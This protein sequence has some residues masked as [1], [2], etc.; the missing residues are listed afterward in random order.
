MEDYA[1]RCAEWLE[2]RVR[3]AEARDPQLRALKDQINQ[4]GEKL[5]SAKEDEIPNLLRQQDK[6]IQA[7]ITRASQSTGAQ[8]AH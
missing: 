8:G 6:A 3:D 7:L 4:P 5:N 2:N 1:A